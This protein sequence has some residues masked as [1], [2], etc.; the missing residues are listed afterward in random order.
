MG[1]FKDQAT[2]IHY[3]RIVPKVVISE[4]SEKPVDLKQSKKRD[5]SLLSIAFLFKMAL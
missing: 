1:Y 4:T 2:S 5:K 3:L